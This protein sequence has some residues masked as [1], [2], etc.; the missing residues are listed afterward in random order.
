MWG[1]AAEPGRRQRAPRALGARGGRTPPRSPD[2]ALWTLGALASAGGR[3]Q[4]GETRALSIK[5]RWG[6]WKR[7]PETTRARVPRPRRRAHVSG[8]ERAPPGLRVALDKVSAAQGGSS[9]PGDSPDSGY[10]SGLPVPPLQKKTSR[11]QT[12]E[13][14][15]AG[16]TCD[17]GTRAPPGA[18]P[19]AGPGGTPARTGRTRP[20]GH[21]LRKKGRAGN[22]GRGPGRGIPAGRGTQGRARERDAP[23]GHQPPAPA[24]R[25]TRE[26]FLSRQNTSTH[27]LPPPLTTRWSLAHRMCLPCGRPALGPWVGKIPLEKAMATHSSVLAWRIPWTQEPG[28]LRPM[29]SQRVQYD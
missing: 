21:S 9:V 4:T 1:P 16:L 25:A 19:R 8:R 14:G 10:R 3:E 22:V 18:A 5:D 24:A 11:A 15:R 27:P 6:D 20:C 26:S 28:G 29:G 13:G 17:T 12:R 7:R 2:A 23:R